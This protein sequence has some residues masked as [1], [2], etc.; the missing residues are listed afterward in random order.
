MQQIDSVV[1]LSNTISLCYAISVGGDNA[2]AY[3]DHP[4]LTIADG[5]ACRFQWTA[6]DRHNRG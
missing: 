4:F 5:T 1:D 3:V 6:Y 2:G